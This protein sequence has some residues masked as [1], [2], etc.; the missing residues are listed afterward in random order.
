MRAAPA[1]IAR[2]L[3]LLHRH[4]RFAGHAAA[5]VAAAPLHHEAH[6]VP[7]TIGRP[8][9]QSPQHRPRRQHRASAGLG[10]RSCVRMRAQ[11]AVGDRTPPAS[12]RQV[13]PRNPCLAAPWEA[14]EN[15]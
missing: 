13:A 2:L 4:G 11:E 15:K 12:P 7:G 14:P 3:C 9:N 5:G 8:P 6:G 1:A 10:P